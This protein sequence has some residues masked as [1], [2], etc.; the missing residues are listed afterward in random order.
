MG[1]SP[2]LGLAT[3]W[4]LI[5]FRPEI[6]F[7]FFCLSLSCCLSKRLEYAC[8]VKAVANGH[9]GSQGCRIGGQDRAVRAS[10]TE[11]RDSHDRICWS[12]MGS[13][14]T[15]PSTTFKKTSMPSVTL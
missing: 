4:L 9:H 11:L 13:M 2:S 3:L 7:V 14:D 8:E 10:A 5:P 12:Q 15:R 6:I 1:G